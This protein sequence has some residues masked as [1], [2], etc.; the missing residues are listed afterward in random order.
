MFYLTAILFIG[1]N[2]A[3][4][5]FKQLNIWAATGFWVQICLAVMF[6]WSFFEKP[7]YHL[8]RNIPLGLLHLWVLV[9]VA[10]ICYKFQ[11]KGKNAVHFLSYFN[12]F[13]VLMFYRY[14]QQYLDRVKIEIIL[15]VMRY[16][17]IANLLI[18]VLQI[19]NLG[20]FLRLEKAPG[21]EF[22]FCVG[23]LGNGTHLSGFLGMCTPLFFWKMRR[24][25]VGALILMLLVMLHTGTAIND[26]S[27]SG[28]AITGV[29]FCYFFKNKPKVIIP[30]LMVLC[31][32]GIMFFHKIPIK[33]FLPQGRVVVWKAYWDKVFIIKPLFGHGVGTVHQIWHKVYPPQFIEGFWYFIVDKVHLE[34]FHFAVELGIIGLILIINLI[35]GFFHNTAHDKTELTLKTIVLGFLLSCCFNFPAHLWMPSIF[36]TFAYAGYIQLKDCNEW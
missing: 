21:V 10:L 18:S 7:K 26:P 25:D 29:L 2:L 14:I 33:F 27:I 17:V 12:F 1:L 6:S 19:F 30:V 36:V 23:F 5:I 24:E 31:F 11:V 34:Y 16:V 8:K 20:E 28:Y 3:Q 15:E 35:R 22:S 9:G 13:C 32:G 4:L